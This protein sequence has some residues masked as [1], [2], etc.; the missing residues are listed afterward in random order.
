MNLRKEMLIAQIS[1]CS[2]EQTWFASL[3][4]ALKGVTAEQA[5]WHDGSFENSIVEIVKHLIFWNER[6]LQEFSGQSVSDEEFTNQSTFFKEHSK[7][8]TDA[9]WNETIIR[10]QNV[11]ARWETAIKECDEEMLDSFAHPDRP[12]WRQISNM[13]LHTAHHSGQI[14]YL[15]KRNGSWNPVKW[16]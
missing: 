10:L 3:D 7:E 1:S 5:V 12:W 8:L 16:D 15:R 14:I 9:E 11:F 2:T 13:L 6:C 4:V